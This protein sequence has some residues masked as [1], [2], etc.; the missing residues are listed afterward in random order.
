MTPLVRFA[1]SPTGQL[2]IGNIRTA[3]LNWL[4]ARKHGGAFWLRLDDT[5]LLRSTEE[6]AE[7]IRHDLTGSA[8]PGR[9]RSAS[10]SASR[11][12]R[13]RRSA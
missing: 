7:A 5:D 10:R 9:A 8:S 2:H 13:R 12:M 11:A 3:M 1:P 4:F 6:F